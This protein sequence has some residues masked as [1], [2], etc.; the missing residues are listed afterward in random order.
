MAAGGLKLSLQSS[1]DKGQTPVWRSLDGSH[2]GKMC[3]GRWL[4]LGPLNQS[5]WLQVFKV[6][7]VS[8]PVPTCSCDSA[9]DPLWGSNKWPRI[10]E[11]PILALQ[12]VSW[13]S[14]FPYQASAMLLSQQKVDECNTC[15]AFVNIQAYVKGTSFRWASNTS[16]HVQGKNWL[17]HIKMKWTY[18]SKITSFPTRQGLQIF[19][20]VF[21][22][23]G[24]SDRVVVPL[25]LLHSV[26]RV[27]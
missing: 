19:G 6:S 3:S 7:S 20:D 23:K 18:R 26:S 16:V 24:Q 8:V 27:P 4:G 15:L 25:S 12:T 13:P 1:S 21:L 2:L 22:M 17:V 10:P 9:R 5:P 14:S 11:L